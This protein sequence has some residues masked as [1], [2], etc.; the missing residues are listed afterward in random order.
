MIAA[1]RNVSGLMLSTVVALV[2]YLLDI[3]TWST[4]A[5]SHLSHVWRLAGWGLDWPH[6][7]YLLRFLSCCSYISSLPWELQLQP[8]AVKHGRDIMKACITVPGF[9][10]FGTFLKALLDEALLNWQK[11]LAHMLGPITSAWVC[12]PFVA[13]VTTLCITSTS[14]CNLR[15]QL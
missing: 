1:T 12:S 8:Q 9:T 10:P 15:A 7:G 13:A 6:P 14:L 4:L 3:L 5:I 2:Y 11:T